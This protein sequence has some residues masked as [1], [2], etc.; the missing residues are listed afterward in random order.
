M[1][2]GRIGKMMMEAGEGRGMSLRPR[3]G[4]GEDGGGRVMQ[5]WPVRFGCLTVLKAS[6]D[7][8]LE[9]EQNEHC[10]FPTTLPAWHFCYV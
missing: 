6:V 4:E 9:N 10:I 1:R 2:V 8:S 5:D 3:G 7:F